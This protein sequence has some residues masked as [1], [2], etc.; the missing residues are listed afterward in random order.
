MRMVEIKEKEIVISLYTGEILL[1][2]AHNYNLVEAVLFVKKYHIEKC[3]CC[4][5]HKH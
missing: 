4:N 5:L 2:L 3:T 1:C